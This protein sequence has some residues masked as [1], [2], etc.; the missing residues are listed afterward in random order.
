MSWFLLWFWS[1]KCWIQNSWLT[2]FSIWTCLCL[3][4]GGSK[5]CLVSEN[6]SSSWSHSHWGSL[7]YDELLFSRYFI[8]VSA[9][10]QFAMS[11]NSLF[12]FSTLIHWA[13]W[14]YKLMF[15]SQTWD[16]FHHYFFKHP[17]CPFLSL[18]LKFPLYVYWNSWCYPTG[19][20]DSLVFILFFS[21]MNNFNN[22]SLSLL[23]LS[24]ASLNTNTEFVQ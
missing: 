2:F 4:S 15:F 23:T 11:R 18:L 21:W 1:T 14:M 16:V 12:N 13:S 5:G 6:S 17:L 8:F 10:W 22:L 3:I 24:S 19:L 9:F 7:V 20:W